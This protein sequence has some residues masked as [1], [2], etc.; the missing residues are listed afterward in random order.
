MAEELAALSKTQTWELVCLPPGKSTIG[1]KWVFNIK[2]KADGT[3][4]RYKARLVAK[5]YNQ[6]YGVDYDETFVPIEKMT[7]VHTLLVVSA[8]M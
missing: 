5:G 4:E 2:T 1:Y 7:F 6:E 3:I 8:I